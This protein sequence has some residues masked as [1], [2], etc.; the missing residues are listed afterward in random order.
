MPESDAKKEKRWLIPLK[1]PARIWI[2]PVIGILFLLWFILIFIVPL[3]ATA[4]SDWPYLPVDPYASDGSWMW[5]SWVSI[6]IV[7]YSVL[8]VLEIILLIGW[9]KKV[10]EAM[11][12]A[13]FEEVCVEDVESIPSE[14]VKEQKWIEEDKRQGKTV[15][16]FAYP[17]NLD[18]GVYGDSFIDI[19][20]DCTL[21]M[22]SMMAKPCALC[23]EREICWSEYK[24]KMRYNYFLGNVD[25]KNGL[26]IIVGGTFGEPEPAEESRAEEIPWPEHNTRPPEPVAEKPNAE[27]VLAKPRKYPKIYVDIERIE[28]I[29]PIRAKT[30]R[31]AGIKH[32]DDLEDADIAELANKV[33]LPE[34]QLQ[35]WRAMAELMHVEDVGE[36][37]SETL[38]RAGVTSVEQ[39]ASSNPA[40][41]ASKIRGMISHSSKRVTQAS[42]TDARV[43]RW[44]E[45]ARKLLEKAAIRMA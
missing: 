41:L 43:A 3:I 37:F 38:V 34:N 42:I 4:P 10:R 25:C 7:L 24:D 22:R 26:R 29:G 28:G 33:W 23:E 8:F 6:G 32:T 12:R 40:K 5:L 18:G 2:M 31:E 15:I 13:M 36:Q 19:D 30:L 35:E 17:I 20:G 11:E 27:E 21:K 45:H 14:I 44:I 39:L 16:G 1:K 9:R